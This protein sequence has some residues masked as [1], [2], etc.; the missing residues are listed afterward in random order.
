MLPCLDEDEVTA[1]TSGRATEAERRS[2]EQHMGDCPACLSWVAVVVRGRVNSDK[3]LAETLPMQQLGPGGVSEPLPLEE[4]QKATERYKLIALLGSGAM[5]VVYRAYDR[6]LERHIALKLIRSDSAG[7][8]RLKVRLVAEAHALAKMTHPNVVTIHDL[9]IRADEIFIAMELIEGS[10]LR[11]HLEQTRAGWKEI[12]AYYLQAA[13]GL[14]AAHDRGL[15]HRDFKPEN[16]LV[17]GSRVVVTDFGLVRP[18]FEDSQKHVKSEPVGT[19]A[20]MAPEQFRGE[21]ADQRTDIFNF[22]ASV[23]ESIYKE[24]P[25]PGDSLAQRRAAVLANTRRLPSSRVQVPGYLRTTLQKGLAPERADRFSSM[26]QLIDIFSEILSSEAHRR[27]RRVYAA[28]AMAIVALFVGGTLLWRRL[29]PRQLCLQ[30]A[31]EL[32]LYW[33]KQARPKILSA[34][35]HSRVPFRNETWRTLDSLLSRY[36]DSWGDAYTQQCD[37]AWGIGTQSFAAVK[38]LMCLDEQQT[39]AKE[40]ADLLATGDGEVWTRSVT[41]ALQLQPPQS[42]GTATPDKENHPAPDTEQSSQPIRK[43]R[44]KLGKATGLQVGGNAAEDAR[45]SRSLYEQAATAAE[46]ALQTARAIGSVPLEADALFRLASI[47]KDQGKWSE[48]ERLF[49][50]CVDTAERARNDLL[51]A[52]SATELLGVIGHD[53]RRSA[54]GARWAHQAEVVLARLGNPSFEMAALRAT[55]A[56]LRLNEGQLDQAEDDLRAALTLR[57]QLLPANDATLG[58][59][60]MNLGAVVQAKG[61][62]WEAASFW[63]QAYALLS[64]ALGSQHPRSAAVLSN[65]GYALFSMGRLDEAKEEYER[66]LTAQTL[67]LGPQHPFI[68]A[69]LMNIAIVYDSLGDHQ[70]ALSY[71]TRALDILKVLDPDSDQLFAVKLNIANYL[72]ELGQFARAHELAN[73]ALVFRRQRYGAN[74][75][76]V[77]DAERWIA[78]YYLYQRRFPDALQHA[79]T[80]L[81]IIDRGLGGENPQVA[82]ALDIIGVAELAQGH[83]TNAVEA[84]RRA[85]AIRAANGGGAP[86]AATRSSLG[87]AEIALGAQREGLADLEV[88]MRLRAAQQGYPEGTAETEFALARALYAQPQQAA[89]AFQLARAALETFSHSGPRWAPDARDARRWLARH[90]LGHQK[91][92]TR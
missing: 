53:Q 39:A 59:T 85:L 20:Y 68:A 28:S 47:R 42:C 7:A 88:A 31:R 74:H 67:A 71:A 46:T 64:A 11:A 10:T 12:V 78:A 90:V 87:R 57:Q 66:A 75:A 8:S 77:G 50:S 62:Y 45:R 91:G 17:S 36:V 70:Q 54:E 52:K 32:P 6:A 81:T 27:R 30:N 29:V 80:A 5:G 82:D 44:R 25:F 79:K 60:L 69:T 43:S 76:S 92:E 1:F 89:R 15:I 40:F 41:S 14:A 84:H 3:A 19:P 49:T 58:I 16:I 55:R 22:C 24:S 56:L 48:A 34:L 37:A 65:M 73:E 38:R 4:T 86:L 26:R 33:S 23:Y 9:G 83:P 21:P 61:K 63:G 72:A 13:H 2:I 35:G 18:I 51:R